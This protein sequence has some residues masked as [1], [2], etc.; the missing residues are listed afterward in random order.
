MPTVYFPTV[1][2]SWDEVLPVQCHLC[3]PEV[4]D[5]EQLFGLTRCVNT[6]LWW[7]QDFWHLSKK[8][9]ERRL[10][11]IRRENHRIDLLLIPVRKTLWWEGSSLETAG[12]QL[13]SIM[14]NFPPA[15]KLQKGLEESEDMA[16][17]Y[18]QRGDCPGSTVSLFLVAGLG[19]YSQSDGKK[20]TK[21]DRGGAYHV[22]C[23]NSGLQ[24]I[25]LYIIVK[26]SFPSEG[27]CPTGKMC[28]HSGL[29]SLCHLWITNLF[30][31]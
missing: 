4:R 18:Q 15:Q 8:Y 1:G 3:S 30:S 10:K 5:K 29:C 6:V 28:V 31:A 26:A 16:S 27:R 9:G 23:A 17:P 2:I 19:R 14:P 25:P 13:K 24:K 7:Y 12:T 20:Q 11:E 22:K 21:M